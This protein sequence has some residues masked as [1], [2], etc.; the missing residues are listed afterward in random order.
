MIVQDLSLAPSTGFPDPSTLQ[1]MSR[2]ALLRCGVQP[3]ALGG[4]RW[5]TSPVTGARLHSYTA[6][7]ERELR[8]A[9]NRAQETFE[10]WRTT[11]APVRGGLLK[12]LG[13][14]LAEHVDDLATLITLEV[15][16]VPVEARGEIHEAIEMC[17]LA[18]GLSRRLGGQTLPSQRPGFR[19]MESWHPLGVVAII[20]PFSFPAAV[21]AWGAPI[22]LVCGNPVIWKPSE[23]APLTALAFARLVDQAAADTGAPAA[24]SQVLLGGPEVGGSLA[25]DGGVTLVNVSGTTET[26][27]SVSP[28]VAARFGRSLLHLGGNNATVVTPS[29][30]LDLAVT[31]ILAAATSAAGQ[32]C[33]TMRRLIVHRSRLDEVCDRLAAEYGRLVVGNPLAEGT[34]VGPLVNGSAFT[35]MR[36]ACEA[37]QQQ[38]GRVVIGGERVHASLAPEAY[39]VRPAVVRMP[40]QSA[41]VREETVAPLLYLMHYD[42]LEEAI[43]LNNGVPQGFSSSIYTTA[44]DEAERFLA[45]DGSDCGIVNV[46]LHTSGAEVGTAFGGEKETG[47]GRQCGSDAW[48]AY[49][50]RVT[51]A[52]G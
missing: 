42:T 28:R 9:V 21:W 27:R 13:E 14:L 19:L 40:Q 51:S 2:G 34:R 37:A 6:C 3:S 39:Y 12:R 41:V 36:S 7:G 50:R 45:A 4:D 38:G 23:H 31:G 17:D 22:A 46:N 5:A 52:I 35:R 18:L 24:V 30:D 16:K 32:R 29:A 48:H 25:D 15:G 43:R 11:P 1:E 47:G 10:S 8:T 33:T 44:S 49:M 20:S 26:G